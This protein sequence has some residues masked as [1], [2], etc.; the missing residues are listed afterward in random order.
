MREPVKK[1]R[2]LLSRTALQ[3][4]PEAASFFLPLH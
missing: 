4:L 1:V 3:H 2:N